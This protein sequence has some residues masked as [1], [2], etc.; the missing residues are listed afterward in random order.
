[1][2]AIINCGI[3][4]IGSVRRAITELGGQAAVATSPDDLAAATAL[5]LPGVG[6]FAESMERFNASGWTQAI[7]GAVSGRGLPLLGICLGMQLLATWGEEGGRSRG[8]GLIDGEVLHLRALGCNDR[9]PHVGWN[10][11]RTLQPEARLLSGIPAETDFYF[12]HSYS[13]RAQ[14]QSD[15]IAVTPYGVDIVA[16]VGR[17]RVWGV[18]FHPEKSS[19][20]GFQVLKNFLELARC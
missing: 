11:V 16:A 19:R 6:S 14:M 20:S 4:N 3:G 9:V 18:Q 12:V 13:F 10:S 1:M 15:V 2:I 8:L 7:V 5:I 17:N